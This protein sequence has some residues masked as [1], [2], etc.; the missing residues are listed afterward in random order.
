M[1]WSDQ[2]QVLPLLRPP[3]TPPARL[4]RLLPKGRK[5]S[6]GEAVTS[7]LLFLLFYSSDLMSFGL[8]QSQTVGRS[9]LGP[10]SDSWSWGHSS[11]ID[12]RAPGQSLSDSTSVS[13]LTASAFGRSRRSSPPGRSAVGRVR[14]HGSAWQS[15]RRSARSAPYY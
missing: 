15:R 8:S 7:I 6:R 12:Q 13:A 2:P 4:C 1:G 14:S 10:T 5:N 3:L 11:H 9:A